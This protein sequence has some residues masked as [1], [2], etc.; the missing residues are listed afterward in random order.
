MQNIAV[1][2][3]NIHNIRLDDLELTYIKYQRTDAR[4]SKVS[5][6]QLKHSERPDLISCYRL[7]LPF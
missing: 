2:S 3:S 1:Q 4:A 5:K 7:R 6:T